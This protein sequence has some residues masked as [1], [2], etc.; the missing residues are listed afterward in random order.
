MTSGARSCAAALALL[1]WLAPAAT[2]A[3]ETA[4]VG[5]D[6]A[7]PAYPGVGDMRRAWQHWTLN[8]Q[9]CHRPDGSG[10]PDTAPRIAGNVA[11][12]LH[13]DGGRAYLGQVPGVASSPLPSADLAEVLNW[14][15]WRFDRADV[16]AAF[17][18]Y[19]ADEVDGLRRTPLHL[20]ASEKR[21]EL[22]AQ[23]QRARLRESRP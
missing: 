18:P 23:A 8:C 21:R 7:E 5:Y 14:M 6:P 2:R 19:T 16:P 10:S 11:K 17:Q 13:A 15:L 1:V 4:G 20:G 9:G 3:D 12:F 22:L